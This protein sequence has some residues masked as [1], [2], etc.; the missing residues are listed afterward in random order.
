MAQ[1]PHEEDQVEAAEPPRRARHL[2]R[3]PP[4]RATVAPVN[5]EGSAG[6]AGPHVAIEINEEQPAAAAAPPPHARLSGG[7]ASTS[8]HRNAQRMNAITEVASSGVG[9]LSPAAE[10]PLIVAQAIM[11]FGSAI[12]SQGMKRP[13][14]IIQIFQ[15]MLSALRMGLTIAMIIEDEDCD[16]HEIPL[17]KAALITYLLFVGVLTVSATLAESTKS[18]EEPPAPAAP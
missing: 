10:L 12:F 17:C 18:E 2:P 8:V 11:S 4:S 14:R 3:I 6:P 5:E 13:E 9:A 1:D 16:T 15:G 7:P